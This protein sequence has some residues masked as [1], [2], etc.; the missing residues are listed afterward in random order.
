MVG[1]RKKLNKHQQKLELVLKH[2]E[3]GM[4]D[5]NAVRAAGYSESTAKKH[6][7]EKVFDRIA[8]ERIKQ[9]R[10]IRDHRPPP[11]KKRP[12]KEI[13]TDIKPLLECQNVE[14][15]ND[16]L[17]HLLSLNRRQLAYIAGICEGKTKKQSEQRAALLALKALTK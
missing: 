8:P 14:F 15:G 11:E 3:N 4:S 6:R 13:K 1:M 16:A 9:A 5:A 17:R 7:K 2:I 10:W 12:K